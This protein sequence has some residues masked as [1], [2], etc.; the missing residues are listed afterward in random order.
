MKAIDY[1]SR[2]E[3]IAQALFAALHATDEKEREERKYF[4][5]KFE[6]LKFQFE[7]WSQIE[8]YD[9]ERL[10]YA[11]SRAGEAHQAL[12]LIDTAGASAAGAII[13]I[14]KLCISMAWEAPA[15]FEKGRLIGSQPLAN[16]IWHARNQALHFE[17]G[18]PKN[19]DTRECL[20][21]LSKEV[22]LDCGQLNQ[23]PRSLARQIVKILEWENYEMFSKDMHALLSEA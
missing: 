16:V 13:Q 5:P 22:G 18:A 6:Y 15:R 9:D 20:E 3:P 10:N 19:K 14:A 21:K 7:H 17:E 23:S 2:V 4:E 12:L 1:L 11:H 8:E